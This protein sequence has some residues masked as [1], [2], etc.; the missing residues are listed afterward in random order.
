[1][2]VIN[3]KYKSGPHCAYKTNLPGPHRT[4]NGAAN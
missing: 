1:M 4:D 2:L 3:L